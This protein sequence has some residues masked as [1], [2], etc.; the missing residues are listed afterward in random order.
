MNL[1]LRLKNKTTLLAL[2]G[3][4]LAF[5][6]QICAIFGVVPAVSQDVLVQLAGLVVNVL[7]AV[8]VVVDPTTAGVK[9]SKQ[10]MGYT[11]PKKEDK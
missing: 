9:D 1:I 6:Y 2:I 10:A 3:A 5:V 11:E 8:G 4:L 7:V